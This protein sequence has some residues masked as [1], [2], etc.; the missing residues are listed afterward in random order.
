[1]EL[2]L[3]YILSEVEKLVPKGATIVV[4]G[5][6]GAIGLSQNIIIK[7]LNEHGYEAT[8]NKRVKPDLLLSLKR[9]GNFENICGKLTSAINNGVSVLALDLDIYNTNKDVVL[10]LLS[11]E[12]IG[13]SKNGMEA[14]GSTNRDEEHYQQEL[15]LT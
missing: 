9:N 15:D 6:L 12:D 8:D 1:M 7:F 2:I 3:V 5:G 14:T 4:S 13:N 11:N 10:K